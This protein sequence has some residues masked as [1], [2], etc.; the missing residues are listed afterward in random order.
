MNPKLKAILSTLLL[1][2]FIAV[3]VTCDPILNAVFLIGLVLVILYIIWM[4]YDAFLGHYQSLTNKED[5]T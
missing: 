5:S 1:F 3:M 2:S 4:V